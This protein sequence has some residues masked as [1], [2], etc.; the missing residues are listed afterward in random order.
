MRWPCAKCFT[1]ALPFHS[2]SNTIIISVL[3][4]RKLWLERLSNLSK[5]TQLSVT[6]RI[7][8]KAGLS[9]KH[10][11]FTMRWTQ[12]TTAEPLFSK[13]TFHNLFPTSHGLFT[14]MLLTGHLSRVGKFRGWVPGL[15]ALLIPMTNIHSHDQ[16]TFSWEKA[17]QLWVSKK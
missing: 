9:P 6:D 7:Q 13:V 10:V 8:T 16:Y 15:G 3:H 1:F 2:H 11:L 5:V 17:K 14:F 12:K 4:T